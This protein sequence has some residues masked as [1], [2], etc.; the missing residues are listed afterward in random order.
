MQLALDT[1]TEIGIVASCPMAR[2]LIQSSNAAGM[3]EPLLPKASPQ[4]T[5]PLLAATRTSDN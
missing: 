2:C 4:P 5:T 3:V 1:R